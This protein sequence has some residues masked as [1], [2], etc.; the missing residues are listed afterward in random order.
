MISIRPALNSD[1]LAI[2]QLAYQAGFTLGL[3]WDNV[4]PDWLV[5]EANGRLVGAIQVMPGRPVGRLEL[6]FIKSDEPRRVKLMAAK[7]LTYTGCMLLAKY[8]SQV[9]MGLVRPQNTSWRKVIEKRG[10][11]NQGTVDMYAWKVQ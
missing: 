8:G 3:E 7:Q 9:A 2:G 10:A 1:G 5:A 6:L 4:E 11:V